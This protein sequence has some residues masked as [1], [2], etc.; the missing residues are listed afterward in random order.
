M[1]KLVKYSIFLFIFYV[2]YATYSSYQE[3]QE[4]KIQNTKNLQDTKIL[5]E[6][7]LTLLE[8]IKTDYS[9]RLEFIN[10][11]KLLLDK[12][13]SKI[14]VVLNDINSIDG[15]S[16]TLIESKL[17]KVFINVGLIKLKIISDLSMFNISEFENIFTR[18]LSQIGYVLPFKY[19]SEVKNEANINILVIKN[20]KNKEVKNE[21]K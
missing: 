9:T 2:M 1:Q 5:L 20:I 19:T 10:S 18:G 3:L 7:K 13:S 12:Y 16:A 4:Q 14:D 21:K 15:F 6:K 11:N 8:K 17:S